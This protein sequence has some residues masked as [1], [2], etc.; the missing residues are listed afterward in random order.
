MDVRIKIENENLEF[1]EYSTLEEFATA[2]PG[3]VKSIVDRALPES[4]SYILQVFST[5]CSLHA[6]NELTVRKF[7]FLKSQADSKP[8]WFHKE[9][10]HLFSRADT[11]DYDHV[12]SSLAVF[13]EAFLSQNIETVKEVD[14]LI[15]DNFLRTENFTKAIEYF[16]GLPEERKLSTEAAFHM[17]NRKFWELFDSA[18]NL[19]DRIGKL[20]LATNC[21]DILDTISRKDGL[22]DENKKVVIKTKHLLKAIHSL[23]NFKLVLVRNSPVTPKQILDRIT[24]SSSEEKYPQFTVI[25]SILEQNPKSYL[26]HERLHK[27]VNDLG[28]FAD[29]DLSIV[30]F[31]RIQSACVESA[32]IDG[33]FDFAYKQTKA[34]IT[35]CIETKN[36]ECFN[37]I[38]LM[39]YQVGKY[40]SSEW[41]GDYDAKIQDEKIGVLFKQREILSLAIK[42][43]K[44]NTFTTDNSRLLVGQ[45]R[46]VNQEIQKWHEEAGLHRSDEVQDAFQSTQKQIQENITGLLNEASHSKNQASEKIS[47]LFVSGLG[48]AIGAKR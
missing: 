31:P 21:L 19:D 14:Q 41:F 44:P 40:I 30:S 3:V 13:S 5:C 22:S 25:S 8:Q 7:F 17:V 12:L 2:P 28:I 39:F 29:F 4:L 48:W 9:V 18:S 37:D 34:L 32:L 1:L 16:H 43:T 33:N 35:Y 27:I 26:A 38:W 45:F 42:Y 24:S 11:Q 10:M 46:H 15:F 47:N 23:K 36:T 6:L 20:K